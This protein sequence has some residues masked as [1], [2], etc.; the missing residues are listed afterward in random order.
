TN[1]RHGAASS[2]YSPGWEPGL[3]A[4]ARPV[5]AH[6]P[7]ERVLLGREALEPPLHQ[8][9]QRI[10][11]FLHGTVVHIRERRRHVRVDVDLTEDVRPAANQ[12]H[13]LGL[14]VEV[15]REIVP[16]GTDV[17][18]VLVLAGGDRGAAYALSDGNARVRRLA[19]RERLEHEL[20]AVQHVGVDR[21]VGRALGLDPVAGHL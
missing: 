15:A 6:T 2:F 7:A 5:R 4:T 10:R 21:G 20:R 11:H 1:T 18:N 8:H 14:G 17:G 19:P 12:H 9:R 3:G 13:E 16:Y